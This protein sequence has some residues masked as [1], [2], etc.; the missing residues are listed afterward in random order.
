MFSSFSRGPSPH[1]GERGFTLIELLVVIAIIAVL[2]AILFPV[3]AS[4]REKARAT[5]CVSNQKQIS[6]GVL[7]Y[8]EDF[9]E[10]MPPA[11]NCLNG[12][13]TG[14][15]FCL[16]FQ[17]TATWVSEIYPYSHSW[18]GISQCP[19]QTVDPDGIIS[20]AKA[21]PAGEIYVGWLTLP[22]YGYNYSYLEPNPFCTGPALDGTTGPN[23]DIIYGVPVVLDR[24]E[25]P[26]ATVMFVDTKL[27]GNPKF[28]YFDSM[29]AESPA[30][31]G[32][33]TISC[34]FNN[35]GWG[36][37][38]FG[39]YTTLPGVN[40][41]VIPPNVTGTGNVDPRHTKGTNVSF[42]DGH[43]K[44]Y[45]PGGLAVGTNWNVSIPN[46]QV[47][48]TNLSQYLWSLKKSGSTDI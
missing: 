29:T 32:P 3:F 43:V 5:T 16:N 30:I 44:W 46:T 28:G 13:W 21:P 1:N 31:A 45:T 15:E 18:L 38:S 37:G 7:Q 48:I 47:L 25:A 12:K 34:A 4:A 11:Y 8:V 22:S 33:S 9:D 24:I 10:R 40:A 42:C 6:L 2:A 14:G 23:V 20:P 19:D 35:G 36:V 26:A 17:F 39:D 41:P 27:I